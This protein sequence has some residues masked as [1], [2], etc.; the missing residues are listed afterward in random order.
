MKRLSVESMAKEGS[1]CASG[2]LWPATSWP[3]NKE[4]REDLTAPGADVNPAQALR[5]ISVSK[6]YH[7]G[8]VAVAALEGVDLSLGSAPSLP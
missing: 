7:S 2:E 6:V 4:Q 5:L 1:A 8:G 3:G